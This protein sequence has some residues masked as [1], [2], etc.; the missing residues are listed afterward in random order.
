MPSRKRCPVC[1]KTID[2]RD[3]PSTHGGAGVEMLTAYL[4]RPLAPILLT[5]SAKS[6]PGA[7]REANAAPLPATLERL[8]AAPQ[9]TSN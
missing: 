5:P 7:I 8:F 2:I 6:Q 1:A 4:P 9:A 3:W